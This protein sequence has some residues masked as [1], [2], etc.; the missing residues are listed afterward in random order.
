MENVTLRPSVHTTEHDEADELLEELLPSSTSP[1]LTIFNPLSPVG[2]NDNCTAPCTYQ[3][4]VTNVVSNIRKS[5]DIITE[6]ANIADEDENNIDKAQQ[7]SQ[8][9]KSGKNW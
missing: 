1:A 4:L 5:S 8:S 2:D 9:Q 3:D 6:P 7:R